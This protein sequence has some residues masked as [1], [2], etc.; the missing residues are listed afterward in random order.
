MARILIVDDSLAIRMI[1]RTILESAGHEVVAEA[2]DGR[3]ALIEYCK[4]KPDLVTMD[5]NMPGMAGLEAIEQL[6]QIDPEVFVLVVSALATKQMILDAMKL[7][8]KNFY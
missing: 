2:A 3:R 8:A 4:H 7:G 5:M 6:M 1:L